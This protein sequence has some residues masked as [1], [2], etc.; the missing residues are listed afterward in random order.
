MVD[1]EFI[2]YDKNDIIGEINRLNLNRAPLTCV[3]WKLEKLVN[4]TYL[5]TDLNPCEPIETVKK[6]KKFIKSGHEITSIG[7]GNQINSKWL[8]ETCGPCGIFGCIQ[9]INYFNVL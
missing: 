5:L 4:N 2:N 7:M 1:G 6:A 9:G 3:N 8:Q